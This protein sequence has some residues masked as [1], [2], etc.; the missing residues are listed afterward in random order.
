M[1]NLGV[2]NPCL[3]PAATGSVG[4]LH[5]GRRS[6]APPPSV[7]V[8]ELF[9]FGVATRCVYIYF[10]LYVCAY[11]SNHDLCVCPGQWSGPEWQEPGGG[12]GPAPSHAYGWDREPV[13]DPH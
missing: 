7:R 10:G 6:P 9:D 2:N 3:K 11:W 12:G 5:K 13:G 4:N 1:L 8:V